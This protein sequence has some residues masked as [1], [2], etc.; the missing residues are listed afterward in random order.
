MRFRN[1]C[2]VLFIILSIACENNQ[3][4]GDEVVEVIDKN[5]LLLGIWISPE[6]NQQI[7]TFTRGVNLPD[8]GYGISF[9]QDET[10]VERTS[11]FCGTPPLTFFNVEGTFTLENDLVTIRTSNFNSPYLW[12]IIELT[13]GKLVVKRELSKQEQEHITLM[14][15]FDEIYNIAYSNK[16]SNSSDWSFIA[17]GSKACGGPQGFIPYHNTIDA[18]SFLEKVKNYSN[19]EKAFNIKWNI[20][21]DC[22]VSIPPKSVDCQNGLP[23]LKY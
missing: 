8:E 12:R 17:Y 18:D 3:V 1:I 9:K 11:G 5:N 21:S 14:N 13:E 7:I 22:A 16:C 2:F 4:I 15:L 20:V 10:L 19:T 23:V 6:Y